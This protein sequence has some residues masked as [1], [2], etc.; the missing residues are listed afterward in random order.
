M[1]GLKGGWRITTS[2]WTPL[3][4]LA[5]SRVFPY[6]QHEDLQNDREPPGRQ[7]R[8]QAAEGFERHK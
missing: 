1:I 3:G 8:R 7:G 6:N 5:L 2:E 4:S